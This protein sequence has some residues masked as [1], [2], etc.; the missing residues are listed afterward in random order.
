[1]LSLF[2]FRLFGRTK[3]ERERAKWF[4]KTLKSIFRR[5]VTKNFFYSAYPC[6]YTP[7]YLKTNDSKERTAEER[8]TRQDI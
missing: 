6:F 3:P 4:P 8:I 5:Y 1:M 7:R 2:S